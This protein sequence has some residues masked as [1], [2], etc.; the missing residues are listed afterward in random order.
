[1][2]KKVIA[3]AILAAAGTAASAQ[4]N[5]TMY[6]VMD[7]GLSSEHGGA[8][9]A[10][11]KITGGIESGS[12]LGFKGSEDL[13]NGMAAIF[14]LEAGIAA[15]TGASGQG[16]VLFGRQAWVGLSTRSGTLTM[17]RQYTPQYL[18]AVFA[19][20]FVSG[21]AGDTKNLIQASANGGRLDNSVKYASP[22]V[23]GASAE[24]IYGAGEVAG[25]TVTA[26]QV[27]GAVLYGAGPF[28]VRLAYHNKNNDT[29]TTHTDSARNTLLAATWKFALATG[30][31]QYGINKGPFSSPLRNAN[32]PFGLTVAPTAASLSRDSTDLMFGVSVPSGP[33][34]LLASYI[35]KND[36]AALDQDATQLAVGYRYALSK[37]TDVYTVYAR[38]S[39][40][41]GA[42]Y[43]VGNAAD[44]GSGNSAFNLGIRH[45][46]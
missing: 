6:G 34:A 3:A 46:F 40:H 37:R 30:Y 22:T 14:T 35:H 12:R 20:P 7:V 36:K 11:N 44:G 23:N 45:T 41:N 43:T 28:A 24:L 13:G 21:S 19:D 39:N 42:T 16:G 33:H 18:A 26:R 15:D 17:G 10:I 4:S 5:V 27:G 8:A 29:A 25:S 32:N 38:I 31:F 1:M 9:G 2:N